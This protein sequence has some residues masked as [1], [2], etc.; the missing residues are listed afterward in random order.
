MPRGARPGE[1]RGGRLKGSL[2]KTTREKLAKAN[3]AE[4][5]AEQIGTP[6]SAT[7]VALQKAMAGRKLAREE[8]EEIV[9]IIKGVVAHVQR[10]V[11]VQNATGAVEIAKGSDLG[12]LKDWLRLF[13]DTCLK[14]AEFQSPKFRAVMVAAAAPGDSGASSSAADGGKVINLDDAV[15]AARVYK[16]IVS[17][18]T[19]R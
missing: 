5:I 18:G 7:A 6:G 3:I 9:P 19:R 12:E 10:Q 13:V 15:G 16:R 2:N 1:R 4:Q 14:L 8:V 17:A 11:M